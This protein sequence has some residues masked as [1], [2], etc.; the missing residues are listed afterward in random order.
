[1]Y[2]I[3]CVFVFAY[4]VRIFVLDSTVLVFDWSVDIRMYYL[5]DEENAR[6]EWDRMNDR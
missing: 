6:H 3:F 1:M 4:G 5:V 2:S